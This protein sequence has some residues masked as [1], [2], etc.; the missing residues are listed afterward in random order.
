MSDRNRNSLRRE[1]LA[2]TASGSVVGL[3]G[4]ADA[5]NIEAPSEPSDDSSSR[6]SS[7]DNQK[8]TSFSIN[9]FDIT[10]SSDQEIQVSLRSSKQ[11]PTVQ[12]NLTGPESATSITNFSEVITDSGGYRYKRTYEVDN[13]G[14]YKATL[15]RAVDVDGNTIP[16]T[17]SATL[18]VDPISVKWSKKFEN[19]MGEVSWWDNKVYFGSYNNNVYGLDASTGEELWVFETENEVTSTPLVVDGTVYIGSADGNLYSLDAET[20]EQQWAFDA[21]DRVI[22]YDKVTGTIY[23]QGYS[24]SGGFKLFAVSIA[25]GN[26][27]WSSSLDESHSSNDKII[28]GSGSVYVKTKASTHAVDAQTGEQEWQFDARGEDLALGDDTLYI[29]GFNDLFAVD[30]NDGTEKWKY[31]GIRYPT[32]TEHKNTLYVASENLHAIDPLS[33]GEK[34]VW[35]GSD[36]DLMTHPQIT[37]GTVYVGTINDNKVYAVSIKDREKQW[38]FETDGRAVGGS[39]TVIDDTVYVTDDYYKDKGTT[40]ERSGNVYA[41]S[42]PFTTQ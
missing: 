17:Y 6:T 27:Q 37:N 16:E 20:G 31:G 18:S 32:P 34:W 13:P 19:Y 14:K 11:L 12:V 21:K 39:P 33:G 3:A 1:F 23:T 28:V 40:V 15:E 24:D 35:K 5:I 7:Q 10:Q 38:V 25:D 41:I 29:G 9:N 42:A 26:Q 30:P 2:Y 22:H 4:C 8:Q 36:S